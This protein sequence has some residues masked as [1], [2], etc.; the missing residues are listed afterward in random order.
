VFDIPSH[1]ANAAPLEHCWTSPSRSSLRSQALGCQRLSILKNLAATFRA[2]PS[3]Q[4][5][6]L[7][8]KPE[9][10]SLRKMVGELEFGFRHKTNKGWPRRDCAINCC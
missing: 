1:L 9:F 8:K 7:W 3:T 2:L 4:C 10:N 5:K 6:E